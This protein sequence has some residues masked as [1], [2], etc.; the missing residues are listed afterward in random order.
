M[1][2]F[3][4][5]NDALASFKAKQVYWLNSKCA[6]DRTQLCSTECALCYVY[7]NED[8][9]PHYVI[10]GCKGTDKKLYITK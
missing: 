1:Q 3:T 10:L 4:S 2:L 5:S 6:F 9:E 7:V 8:N